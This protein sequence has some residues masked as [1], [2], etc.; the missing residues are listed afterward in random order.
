MGALY[1]NKWAKDIARQ[2]KEHMKQLKEHRDQMKSYRDKRD[3]DGR[4]LRRMKLTA[5]EKQKLMAKILESSDQQYG[6]ERRRK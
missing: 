4:Q 3:V 1:Q 2:H 5:E 6:K